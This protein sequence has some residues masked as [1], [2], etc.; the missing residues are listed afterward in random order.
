MYNPIS[1]DQVCSVL[2]KTKV[3]TNSDNCC[4]CVIE[5]GSRTLSEIV[6]K[7]NIASNH[8]NCSKSL[9]IRGQIA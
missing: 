3:L 2:P 5:W 9:L 7:N 1:Y 8:I 6:Y 4:H